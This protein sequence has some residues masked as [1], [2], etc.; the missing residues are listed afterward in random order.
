MHATNSRRASKGG[1]TRAFDSAADQQWR[2]TQP[3]LALVVALAFFLLFPPVGFDSRY[4]LLELSLVI[5]TAVLLIIVRSRAVIRGVTV[6][7]ALVALLALMGLSA[8]WSF[9]SW[10]TARDALTFVVLAVAALFIVHAARLNTILIGIVAGGLLAL[11][12]SLVLIVLAPEQAFYQK[13]AVQGLYGNRNGFGY[14]ILMALPAAMAVR[15]AFR[16]GL[17]V[18]SAIIIALAAGVVASN[19][20]T[21]IFAMVLLVG[22]WISAAVLRR[23]RLYAAILVVT[24]AVV[25]VLAVANFGRVLAFLGKEPTLN[26][27][28][29]IW[30]AVLSVMPQSPVIGFGWSRSWPTGSPHSAAVV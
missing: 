21:S 7:T 29:E 27:R 19:S 15:L 22:V 28:S 8:A 30:N 24:A 4:A 17:V 13:G 10:E 26:G 14:V 2:L 5:L 9:A 18:K 25:A 16:G 3:L 11:G 20:K 1:L 6:P 12:G 23:N